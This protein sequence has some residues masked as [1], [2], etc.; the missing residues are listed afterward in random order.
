MTSL[1]AQDAPI[2]SYSDIIQRFSSLTRLKRVIAY[3]FRFK[4][5]ARHITKRISGPLTVQELDKALISAIKICQANEFYQELNNLRNKRQLDSK[6]KLLTLHPFL[7]SDSIIRVGGKLRH[8]PIEYSKKYP[9]I[10]PNKHHLTELIIKNTHYRN[11]HAG[12]QAILA[13]VRNS[14]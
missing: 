7:D 2:K 4:D 3:C 12:P 11:L 9:I 6:S 1:I 14:Y 8:A 5:N 13:A 10:L